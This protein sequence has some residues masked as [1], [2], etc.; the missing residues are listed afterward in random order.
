MF[1]I[2]SQIIIYKL[3]LPICTHLGIRLYKTFL[4]NKIV[5]MSKTPKSIRLLSYKFNVNNLKHL[6]VFFYFSS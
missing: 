2:I 3:N 6:L 4:T 1:A 5:T